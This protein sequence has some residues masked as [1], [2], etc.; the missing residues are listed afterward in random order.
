MQPEALLVPT[1][2]ESLAEIINYPL[3]RLDG[4]IPRIEL[5]PPQVERPAT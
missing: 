1:Q 5:F 4:M 2:A 3:R